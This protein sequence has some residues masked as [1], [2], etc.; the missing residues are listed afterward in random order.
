MIRLRKN[1]LGWNLYQV[2]RLKLTR[3]GT[4]LQ[5]IL[6]LIIAISIIAKEGKSDRDALPKFDLATVDLRG[7]IESLCAWIEIYRNT[8]TMLKDDTNPDMKIKMFVENILETVGGDAQ[9]IALKGVDLVLFPIIRDMYYFVVM[10]NIIR[11]SVLII[12]NIQQEL[13]SLAKFE[14]IPELLTNPYRA[15]SKGND[16]V[17]LRIHNTHM[18]RFHSPTEI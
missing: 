14:E 4:T 11:P 17:A 5:L 1:L 2:D 13:E 16:Y 6:R 15:S 7:T 18:L 12:D 9:L 8:T 10:F 3:T